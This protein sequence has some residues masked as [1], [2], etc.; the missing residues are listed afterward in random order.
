MLQTELI[1]EGPYLANIGNM[2]LKLQKLQETNS[3]VQE[4]RQQGRED[5]E[6]VDRVFEYQ[7][8]LFV[9]EAIRI[10]LISRYHDNFLEG[11]FD[12]KKTLELL[13]WKFY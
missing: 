8:L 6:K 4:L 3:E 10:E 11:P 12:I 9:S 13:A 1:N 7:G 5:Y 2:K